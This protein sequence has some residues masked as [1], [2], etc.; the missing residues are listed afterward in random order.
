MK[1]STIV[2]AVGLLALVLGLLSWATTLSAS[3]D[4]PPNANTIVPAVRCD[5]GSS[6]SSTASSDA[7]SSSTASSDASSS[8][9]DTTF[10]GIQFVSYDPCSSSSSSSYSDRS[11]SS[12]DSSHS[13][14]SHS[15]SSYSDRSHSDSDRS[16]SSSSSSSSDAPCVPAYSYLIRQIGYD[17]KQSSKV[18]LAVP[19]CSSSSSSSS[20]SASS[21]SSS[22]SVASSSSSSSA[23]SSSASSVPTK[24]SINLVPIGNPGDSMNTNDGFANIPPGDLPDGS[25]WGAYRPDLDSLPR[26]SF[27]L[28]GDGDH[29]IAVVVQD[30]NTNPVYSFNSPVQ[31]CFTLSAAEVQAAGGAQNLS[32]QQWIGSAWVTVPLTI[33]PGTNNFCTSVTQF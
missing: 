4:L 10:G 6:S 8:S 14:R 12:S 32:I 26:G 13:D 5:P 25:R 22:S 29:L 24:R 9:L 18:V 27:T 3:N 11:H 31:V 15:D 1:V 30:P 33:T 21:S 7:S 16:H 17:P 20:S 23:S 2:R 28:R 19:P